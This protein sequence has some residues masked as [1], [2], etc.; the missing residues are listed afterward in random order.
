MTRKPLIRRWS[1]AVALS[2]VGLGGIALDAR[3]GEYQVGNCEADQF[4][5]STQAFADFATRGMK[6]RRACN[7]EG[8]G[9]RGLVTEN[10]VRGGRVPR[11][12]RAIVT[13][14]APFGTRFTT[15]RWAGE[16][17][18]RDCGYALQLYADG[19]GARPVAI[20]N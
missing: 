8:P 10:V 1:W 18:R 20:K 15:F 19:G 13:V 2:A 14:T 6:I 11:G 3:A 4:N 7:P 9:L 5:F 12:A 16:A 17:R